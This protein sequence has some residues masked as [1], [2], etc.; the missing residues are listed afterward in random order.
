MSD[1]KFEIFQNPL[2][3]NMTFPVNLNY[4]QRSLDYN[5]VYFWNVVQYLLTYKYI[6][7]HFN[8]III[9]R[10]MWLIDPK[11]VPTEIMNPT[12]IEWALW[13]GRFILLNFRKRFEA[14]RTRPLLHSC[15]YKWLCL[16]TLFSPPYID[17]LIYTLLLFRDTCRCYHFIQSNI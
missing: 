4:S 15:I 6:S 9:I 8:V 13:I 16:S 1:F 2:K 17:F 5:L 11:Q 10:K 3:D 7:Q 14:P 12:G